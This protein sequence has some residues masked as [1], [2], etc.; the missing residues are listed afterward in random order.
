MSWFG[1]YMLA[2]REIARF[3]NVWGQTIVPPVVTAVL[4]LFVFGTA[5]GDRIGSFDGIPYL[6]FIAPGLVLQNV[7]QNAYS[8]T[9]SSLFDARR[10]RYVEDPLTSPISDFQF[11]LAYV[12]GAVA[13]GVIVGALTLAIALPIGEGWDIQWVPFLGY[14]VLV[15]FLFGLI[16][17]FAGMLAS[18][19]DHVFVPVTFGLTPLIF[20]GGMF[21]PVS[22]LPARLQTLSSYNPILYMM[23]G[24]RG[25]LV[26]SA[27][28]WWTLVALLIACVALLVY[29]V[30][31]VPRRLRD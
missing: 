2:R 25:S 7:I 21:Y 27:T 6:T 31:Q 28:S 24:M 11:V 1:T 13:R 10:A 22:E 3:V 5:L 26:G 4:F 20:L 19:W 9:S 23:E 15:S 14:L 16:G 30:Q 29:L 8:N 18:R 17:F 12:L